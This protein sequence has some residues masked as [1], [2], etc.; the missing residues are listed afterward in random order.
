MEQ[1]L[2]F[3][4][5]VACGGDYKYSYKYD[6]KSIGYGLVQYP[7]NTDCRYSMT[8]IGD[9]GFKLVFNAFDLESSIGCE[10]DNLSI[11]R[12]AISDSN[13]IT[14]RCGKKRSDLVSVSSQ[15]TAQFLTNSHVSKVGFSI[16]VYGWYIYCLHLKYAEVLHFLYELT[17]VNMKCMK[18]DL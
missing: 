17:S 13:L 10:N 1:L 16:S 11:Y 14:K 4:F 8:S 5:V 15:L 7:N 12:G 9:Y 2:H 3:V 6:I 18:N